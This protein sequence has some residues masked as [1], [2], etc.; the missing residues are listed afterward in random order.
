M[1]A[2]LKFIGTFDRYADNFNCFNQVIM[3]N[4]PSTGYVRSTQDAHMLHIPRDTIL[5]KLTEPYVD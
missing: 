1:D 5:M 4:R 3:R 2:T